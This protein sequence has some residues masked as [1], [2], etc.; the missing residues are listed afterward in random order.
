[1]EGT[2]ISEASTPDN[3]SSTYYGNGCATEGWARESIVCDDRLSNTYDGESQEIGTY[4]NFQ[5]IT[6]GVGSTIETDNTNSPDT[7]CPLG[8]Q[9]PYSGTGGAYYDKSKSLNYMFSFYSINTSESGSANARSYPVSFIYSGYFL[10]GGLSGVDS[11]NVSWTITKY[12]L[13]RAYRLIMTRSRAIP[14]DV[15]GIV[16]LQTVR[17]DF[18]ISNL[19]KLPMASA[20]T[21]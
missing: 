1:M 3:A 6:V 16:S 12:N 2:D 11:G 19:E 4:Y 15:E 13:N 5:A 7:F 8:W 18:D 21:H 10:S 9:L 20:F 17:C 14:N